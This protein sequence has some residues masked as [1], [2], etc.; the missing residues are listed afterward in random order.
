MKSYKS[1]L[2][3]CGL[4]IIHWKL[5]LFP[6]LCLVKASVAPVDYYFIMLGQTSINIHQNVSICAPLWMEETQKAQRG[7]KHSHGDYRRPGS[8][9]DTGVLLDMCWKC[10][11]SYGVWSNYQTRP[12]NDSLLETVAIIR[13]IFFKPRKLVVQNQ[14]KLVNLAVNIGDTEEVILIS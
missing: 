8:A 7:W 12:L 10:C 4:A 5:W 2:P 1:A 14:V 9:E 13:T 3:G 6:W 11:I